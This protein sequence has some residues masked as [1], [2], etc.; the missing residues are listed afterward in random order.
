MHTPVHMRM[1]E[2]ARVSGAV[3][4]SEQASSL[5]EGQRQWLDQVVEHT[6]R[7]LSEIA[8]AAGITPST[9]TRFRNSS[10]HSGA[11]NAATVAQV[12]EAT[13]VPAPLALGA[14]PV[15]PAPRLAPRGLREAEAAQYQPEVGSTSG[16]DAAVTALIAGQRDVFAYEVRGN[17]LEYEHIRPGDL[18]IVTMGAPA[19]D[20]DIVCA[21]LYDWTNRAGTQTVWRRYEAPYLVAAGPVEGGR[22]PRL[23]D[24]EA[25]AISGVVTT[26][27][28]R[29][30]T[31]G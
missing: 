21:Q 12:A 30:G 26:V 28:R 17:A 7:T 2:G 10:S 20:G 27:L 9:L 14:L 1:H 3:T 13:G 24:N 23:V 15:P 11:L 29:V 19:R 5:A 16:L 22:K 31:P 4:R 6:G 18:L 8:R 25:V